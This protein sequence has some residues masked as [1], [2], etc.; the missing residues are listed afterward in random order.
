MVH[1]YVSSNVKDIKKKSKK[2]KSCS[3]SMA[4]IQSL[5]QEKE[6]D[7]EMQ[8]IVKSTGTRTKEK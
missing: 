3:L 2:K 4:Y 7:E 8:S 1:Y 6:H 5:W